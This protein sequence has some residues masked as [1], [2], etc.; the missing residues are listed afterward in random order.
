MGYPDSG[1]VVVVFEAGEMGFDEIFLDAKA[2]CSIAEFK[3]PPKPWLS[4]RR[5]AFPSRHP[6]QI[7]GAARENPS[8]Q[9][10]LSA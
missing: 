1:G 6:S 3:I 2:I 10:G 8:R 5:E 7:C 9:D 4:R